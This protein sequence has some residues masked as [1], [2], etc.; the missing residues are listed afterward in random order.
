MDA[1]CHSRCGTLKNPHC[2]M[3]Q[4]AKHRLTFS[5]L[6]LQCWPLVMTEKFSSGR[7]FLK[8]TKMLEKAF[9]FFS[10]LNIRII[11]LQCFVYFNLWI[12]HINAECVG[13]FGSECTIPCP[14]GFYG[15][16]C[17]EK[18]Q[19]KLCN[20]TSGECENVSTEALNSMW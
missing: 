16:V 20:S 10:S 15:I 19:C 4:S 8:Q 2:S 12:F 9:W 11:H 5:A 14:E 17:R 18:C 6:Q 1:P 3:V 7:K 13:S